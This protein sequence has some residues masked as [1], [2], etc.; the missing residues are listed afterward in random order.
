[1]TLEKLSKLAPRIDNEG[2]YAKDIIKELADDGFFKLMCRDD[3][4]KAIENIAKVSRECGTTG[5]CVWCQFALAW[6][7]LN[8]D[9]QTLKTNYLS[10]ITNG[11][12]LGGTALSNPIK[13]FAS[14]EK[15]KLKARRV[16]GGYIINGTLPWVSNIE[17]GHV[18]AA[19][20]LDEQNEPIMGLI[21]CDERV[22]LA[23]EIKYATLEGSA[24]K[25]VV[26][27][28]YF[29]SDDELLTTDI[30]SYLLRITPGFVLLQTGIAA[31]II[32]S[33]IDV[34]KAS[35][36]SH[37][38][39]NSYLPDNADSLQKELD[40]AFS[41]IANLANNID[42]VSPLEVLK[43]RL[44]GSFLVQKATNA[45]VL[46][47]GTKGYLKDAKASRL[48]REGNFV[49]IVTPSVK[50]LIKEINDAENGGGCVRS[51]QSRTH[52]A[53]A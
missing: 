16:K 29:L 19:I 11:E 13:A 1:M 45:A 41:T 25:S 37:A 52:K 44:A 20:A 7:V 21:H 33:S 5:F 47:S 8:S 49:L 51:W 9:N 2:I 30:Y 43:V 27:R 38:H 34:I 10:K 18:F 31:G 6:Y 40:N 46:H 36:K 32:N 26:V 17:F 28:E 14:I 50:H 24:T 15:V 42:E 23:S 3:L 4:L 53:S 39:I 48:Q 12:I 35:G 22:K